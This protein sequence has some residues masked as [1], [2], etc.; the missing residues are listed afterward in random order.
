[1]GLLQ[2]EGRKNELSGGQ[3]VWRWPM[4]KY[5][6]GEHKQEERFYT[7]VMGKAPQALVEETMYLYVLYNTRSGFQ[8]QYPILPSQQ[9]FE[10]SVYY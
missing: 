5:V 7:W 10:K 1:M 2:F 9:P 4:E 3:P 8:V 6:R